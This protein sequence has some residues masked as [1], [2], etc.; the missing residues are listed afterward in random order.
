MFM[1]SYKCTNRYCRYENIYFAALSNHLSSP[2]GASGHS[3]RGRRA[4]ERWG[5]GPESSKEPP[6]FQRKT[7]TFFGLK[8]GD[9][10]GFVSLE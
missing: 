10:T 2:T 1:H 6:V 4:P 8:S 7:E 9:L 5:E 3:P